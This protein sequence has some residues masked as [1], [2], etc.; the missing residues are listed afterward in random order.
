MQAGCFGS[1]H[2]DFICVI[3]LDRRPDRLALI[4][5]QCREAEMG[6]LRLTAIDG[7][8]IPDAVLPRGDGLGWNGG[9]VANVMSHIAALT[10]AKLCG[11]RCALVLEDDAVFPPDFPQRANDL[12][13]RVPA[14]WGLLE[15][16]G[17]H[18]RAP[19]TVVPGIARARRTLNSHGYIVR[20]EAVDQ[21]IARLASGI[22]Y[23]DHAIAT[24]QAV[25]PT[26]MPEDL[27]VYQAAGP[28]D[29]WGKVLDAADGRVRVPEVEV[30]HDDPRPNAR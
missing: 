24:A 30:R 11:A 17:W 14:D 5:R 1:G 16:G 3:N 23:A 20:A 27:T 9:A 25:V 29:I 26:Y 2:I 19:E 21:L 6:F 18:I 15:F 12:M 4:E 8:G 22:N 13:S 10:L 7:K 28:S